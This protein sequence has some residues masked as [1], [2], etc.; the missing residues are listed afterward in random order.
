VENRQDSRSEAT[1]REL[2]AP[3]LDEAIPFLVTN[4]TTAELVKVAENAFLATKISFINAIA[5]VCEVASADVRALADAIGGDDRMGRGFFAA[6]LG[7]GG[8]CLS[9]DLRAFVTR[10]GELG[11]G[12]SFKFLREIDN[13]NIRR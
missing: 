2:Y 7:F 13:I 8:G 11:V 3:L 12:D 10:A 4:L 1:I 9:K 6:G 5:E